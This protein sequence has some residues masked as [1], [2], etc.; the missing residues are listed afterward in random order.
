MTSL[1]S[2]A[3]AAA[4]GNSPKRRHGL[5]H[6]RTLRSATGR[7]YVASS[8]STYDTPDYSTKLER[9]TELFPNAEILAARGLFTSNADWRQKWPGIVSQIDALVFFDDADGYIGYGV[10]TEISD[11]IERG[12]PVYALGPGDRLY[13]FETE[14]EVTLRPWDWRQFALVCYVVSFTSADDLAQFQEHWDAR[15]V[16]TS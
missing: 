2:I 14:I 12:I 8:L 3:R 15:K 11:A 1:R 10:W 16:G 6:T 7:V 9:I 13:D 4:R 5:A